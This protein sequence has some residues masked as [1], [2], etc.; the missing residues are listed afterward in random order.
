MHRVIVRVWLLAG[1]GVV[2]I[3]VGFGAQKRVQNILSGIFFLID[4]AF[5]RGEYIEAGGLRGTVEAINMRSLRL[6]HHLGA[7]QT[8][9]YSEIATVKNLSRDWV[10]M[11]LELRLPCDVD[12]EKV[13]KLIRRPASRCWPIRSWGRT[14]CCRS[15]PR[16]YCAWRNRR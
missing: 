6:R 4:D 5:R 15:S 10:T 13:R 8:L 11:K 3:A 12:I 2:G 16:A 1:A 7:V 9:S 14:S